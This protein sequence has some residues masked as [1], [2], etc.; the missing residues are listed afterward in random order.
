MVATV[1]N[2]TNVPKH[3]CAALR[4]ELFNFHQRTTFESPSPYFVIH[5][6]VQSEE[7]KGRLRQTQIDS[8]N[9]RANVGLK[10]KYTRWTK[11]TGIKDTRYVEG[12]RFRFE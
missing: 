2:L 3:N 6:S 7:I 10:I 12:Y 1:Y 9:D 8:E 4:I 11:D 5:S